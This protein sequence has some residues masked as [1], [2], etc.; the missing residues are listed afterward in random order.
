MRQIA[1]RCLGVHTQRKYMMIDW[2]YRDT[3]REMQTQMENDIQYMLPACVQAVRSM[4]YSKFAHIVAEAYTKHTYTH[5]AS[6]VEAYA[7]Q[8]KM[9]VTKELREVYKLREFIAQQEDESTSYVMTDRQMAQFVIQQPATPEAAYK[10]LYR[11]STLLKANMTNF[12]RVLH[13][14][15]RHGTFS[16]HALRKQ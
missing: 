5:R 4:T 7:R 15:K 16:M 8:Y 1:H 9:Q 14:D 11:V 12:M 2:R 13:T 3:T 6:T 10:M